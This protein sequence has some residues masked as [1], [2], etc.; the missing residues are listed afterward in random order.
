MPGGSRVIT[1]TVSRSTSA[2]PA[3]LATMT[4]STTCAM[5]LDATQRGLPRLGGGR[6]NL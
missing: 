6:W 1:V 4:S 3:T 2:G 5:M